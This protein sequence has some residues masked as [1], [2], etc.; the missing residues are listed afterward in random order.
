MF[1]RFIRVI[2]Y[3]SD[4]FIFIAGFCT[5]ILEF[6]FPFYC[7]W[8]FGLSSVCVMNRASV[9]V[10]VQVYAFLLCVWAWEWNCSQAML[11]SVSVDPAKQFPECLYQLTVPPVVSENSSCF[12]SWYY[13][14]KT[15][16]ILVGVGF[17]VSVL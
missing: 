13:A 14:L 8:S 1:V 7:Y 12:L 9:N 16:A 5:N 11:I 10:I 2:A 4:L 17:V 6:I 3:G 15:L